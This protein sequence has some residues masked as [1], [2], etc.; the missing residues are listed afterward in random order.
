MK[1]SPTSATASPPAARERT[2]QAFLSGKILPR[3]QEKLAVVYVRQSTRGQVLNHQESTRL[4]YGLKGRAVELGWPED[5]VLVIDDDLGQSGATAEAR[6]GF[7]RLVSEV[8]LDHV[9]IILGVEM[10]RLARSCR[11][12]H[13]LLEVCAL[14]GTLIADLDGIYDPGDYNDRLLLGL[15]GT[16]SEAELHILKQR[17]REG[18]LQK[19]RRGELA[20]PVPVGYHRRPSGEVVLDPDEEVRHVVR[21]VFEKF[22]ELGTLNALLRYL[23]RHGVKLGVRP[24]TGPSKGELEWRRPNRMTLQ[25]MLKHPIYAGAYA[26]GRRQVDPRRKKAGRPSTGRVVMNPDDWFVLLKNRLPAYISWDEYEANLSRLRANRAVADQA[27][28]VRKGAALLSGILVCGKCGRRMTVRYAGR[29]TYSCTRQRTDYG[30]SICQS[31]S[32]PSLD[33]FIGE[34]VMGVLA[35]SRLQLSL[36]AAERME[37]ERAELHGLWQKRLERAGYEA[38]RASRQYH[39]A[40]PEHRLVTRVLER[41]WEG[42]LAAKKELEE[43]FHRFE[44]SRPRLLS[45]EE[46]E[47]IRRLAAD[48]PALWKARE[49]TDADRKKILRQLVE[50][51]VVD[52]QGES[53]KVSV[54]IHWA[55]G[56][57][58]ET[59]FVRP[60]A[61]LTQLSYYPELCERIQKLAGENL[62]AAEIAGHLNAEGFRPPKRRECFGRQGVIDLMRRLGLAEENARSRETNGLGEDE[63]YLRDLARKIPMPD[64]TLY[65]WLRRGWV[66]SRREDNERRRW[67]I[68]ADAAEIERLRALRRRP[69]GYYTRRLWIEGRSESTRGEH[70]VHAQERD[71]G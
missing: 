24:R 65:N 67:I 13:Q 62:G 15:K 6:V 41:E 3:H 46:R 64:V 55:G 39:L 38:E 63:W 9:G 10:S 22:K 40:E 42:K 56:R 16:M 51:V 37:K 58:T 11:D 60:V 25:N 34:M 28:A 17:M 20:V 66:S 5:R 54:T 21:L 2:T 27:G 59:E 35:A 71:A 29:H 33:R 69:Q 7:Q 68:T 44:R 57:K 43:D 19:A 52:V 30:G 31:L 26:Y 32:G 36:R 4:Q 70:R 49:T 18:R 53:E 1:K 45:D 47:K 14:F 61:K 12:F 48:C 8:S 50:K 23:V